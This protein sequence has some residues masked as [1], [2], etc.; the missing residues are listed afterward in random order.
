MVNEFFLKDTFLEMFPRIDRKCLVIA[1]D[2]VENSEPAC[3]ETGYM[4]RFSIEEVFGRL[5]GSF[6][7]QETLIGKPRKKLVN[8]PRNL[9][10]MTEQH[11]F[12]AST[13]YR[14]DHGMTDLNGTFIY[15]GTVLEA[16]R[17]ELKESAKKLMTLLSDLKARTV[18]EDPK[19]RD[20]K[21]PA[22]APLLKLAAIQ[23]QAE[24]G[25]I[26]EDYYVNVL[27]QAFPTMTHEELYVCVS[28]GRTG[29][30]RSRQIDY[31]K[32]VSS[33]RAR[34]EAPPPANSPAPVH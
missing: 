27:Q 16:R 34:F 18:Q 6:V 12:D 7:D 9:L 2:N 10:P 17:P 14:L 22:I 5:D 33:L 28:L 30:P 21:L 3:R 11:R 20:A 24:T 19:S 29:E 8:V 25:I 13:I 4:R 1:L 31:S 32:F 15:P 23:D 26:D